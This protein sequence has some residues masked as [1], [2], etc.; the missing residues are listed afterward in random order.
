MS[1]TNKKEKPV[2]AQKFPTETPGYVQGFGFGPNYGSGYGRNYGA[3]YG[4]SYV[5]G[6]PV[7]GNPYPVNP[8]CGCMPGYGPGYMPNQM[9]HLRVYHASPDAVFGK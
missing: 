8:G 9:A 5:P 2:E 4:P 3:G 1:E 6:C 7:C